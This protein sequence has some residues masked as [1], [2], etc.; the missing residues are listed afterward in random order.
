LQKLWT[1]RRWRRCCISSS[2]QTW[3]VG[4]SSYWP[5]SQ[6]GQN[7]LVFGVAALDPNCVLTCQ[8]RGKIKFNKQSSE[9][10]HTE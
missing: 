8:K 3:L 7:L 1:L 5:P 6:G 10:E 2:F 4:C 9:K